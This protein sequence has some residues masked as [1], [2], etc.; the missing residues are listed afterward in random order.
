[1]V[2]KNAEY[3]ISSAKVEQCPKVELPEYAFIGRSNVGKSSLINM[4]ADNNKL[5]K[6]SATP[7]KTILINHFLINKATEGKMP[8]S[9]ADRPWYLVDLPGYGYAEASKVEQQRWGKIIDSYLESSKNL[10]SAVLLVDV[11]HAPSKQ[12]VQM[13]DYLTFNNIP[14][15]IRYEVIPNETETAAAAGKTVCYFVFRCVIIKRKTK[16]ERLR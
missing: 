5:A 15:T 6:T 16:Q 10:K 1:M 14:V 7:G 2:I 13:L 4:L 9:L 8:A 11:R 12:D 3:L